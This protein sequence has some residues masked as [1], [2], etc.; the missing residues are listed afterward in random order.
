M[1]LAVPTSF[2]SFFLSRRQYRLPRRQ[3]IH[4]PAIHPSIRA[5]NTSSSV[6][7]H[8]HT[9]TIRST[10]SLSLSLSLPPLACWK[11]GL[12]PRRDRQ[13]G[14]R[15]RR[16]ESFSTNFPAIRPGGGVGFVTIRFHAT[17]RAIRCARLTISNRF[18]TL[19]RTQFARGSLLTCVIKMV[20]DKRRSQLWRLL[21]ETHPVRAR[22]G[23]HDSRLA[24]L[25]LRFDSRIHALTDV[26]F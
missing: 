22:T 23:R 11:R 19:S 9:T 17:N 26:R 6:T 21:A 3:L 24:S 13:G 25:P 20:T 16:S 18:Y 7:C 1:V 15:K 12:P 4:G 2:Q 10:L 5:P 14:R 8:N